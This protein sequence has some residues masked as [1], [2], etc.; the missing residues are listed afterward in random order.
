VITET[1]GVDIF[2]PMTLVGAAVVDTSLANGAV[3]FHE[4]VDG[5]KN[6]TVIAGSGNVFFDQNV[7][8]TTPIGVLTITSA[9]SVTAAGEL[10]ASSIVQTAG[11]G[12]TTFAGAVSTTA[13]AGIALT[14]TQFEFDGLVTTANGGPLLISNSGL[15]S[16]LGGG[17]LSGALSQ[18]G[19]GAVSISGTTSAGGAVSFASAASLTGS[20]S[21]D[22]SANASNIT[23][24]GGITGANNSLLLEAGTTGNIVFGGALSGLGDLTISDAANVTGT[25]ISA[26]TITQSAGT[27]LTSLGNLTTSAVG[28]IALTGKSFSLSGNLIT[29]SLG[30][31]AIVNTGALTLNAG[32]STSI[33]G[34]FSQS[35]GGAI[36]LAGTLLT[37][38]QPISF[39]NDLSLAAAASVSSGT[40]MIAFSGNIDGNKNLTLLGGDLSFGPAI[41]GNTPLST[42]TIQNCANITYPPTF[43]NSIIQNG[44]S[45]LTQIL[46][47]NTLTAT[48]F[49]SLTGTTITQTGTLTTLGSA[50]I[51]ITNSD[52]YTMSGAVNSA[53]L[54]LQAGGGA[55]H[56][57]GVVSSNSSNIT[58]TDALSLTGSSAI[59]TGT[60]IG[61]IRLLST[62]AGAGNDLT[63]TAGAGSIT[64]NSSATGIGTFTIVSGSESTIS[65]ISAAHILQLAGSTT[66]GALTASGALGISLTGSVFALTGNVA[67][68]AGPL[69]IQNT[70][71]LTLSGTTFAIGGALTQAGLGTTTVSSQITASDVISFTG[72]VITSGSPTLDTSAANKAISFQRAVDGSGALGMNSGS[73]DITLV[74]AVG[75]TTRL[76]AL[77]I[78]H[79]G[80]VSA[81]GIRAA[82]MTQAAGE[83]TT[84]ILGNIDTTSG[85]NLTGTHFTINGSLLSS[86]AGSSS[87]AHTG[88]LNLTA[89]ASTLLS[90]SFTESGMGGTVSLSG[91][92]HAS[93][94]NIT[95]ANPITLTAAATFNSDGGGDILISSAIDGPFDLIYTAGTGNI[96]LAAAIGGTTPISSLTIHSAADVTADFGISSGKIIQS[97]GSGLTLFSGP[98]ITTLSDGIVLAGTQFDFE[99]AVTT[100]GGGIVSIAHSGSLNLPATSSFTLDGAFSELGAGA[101]SL[102]TTITTTGD[103]ISFAGAVTLCNDATLDSDTGFGSIVFGNTVSGSHTLNLNTGEGDITFAAAVG[104]VPLTRLNVTS[105]L[106]LTA[107]DIHAGIIDIEGVNRLALFNGTLNTSNPSGVTLSGSAFTL[108][109]NVSTSGGTLAI[110][111]SA[112]LTIAP[113]VTLSIDGGFTQS[114]TGTIYIGGQLTTQNQPILFSGPILLTGNLGLNS[115]NGN[116]TFGSDLN[117]PHSVTITAGTGDVTVPAAFSIEEPL[118]NFTVV[119]SHDINLNGIGSNTAFLSGALSLTAASTISL[120]NTTYSSQSQYYMS[121]ADLDFIHPGLIT[122][123]TS[124]GP[125]IFASASTHLNSSTDLAINTNGGAFSFNAIHGTN[126]ENL[127]I[128]TGSGTATLGALPN[129]GNIN[130]V[131]VNA[132]EIFL[133]AAMNLTNTAF[134]SQGSILNIASPVDIV[135]DNTA[136]FNALGG[137]VGSLVSPILVHTNNLIFAGGIDLAD[138]NGSSIDDTVHP[139]PSNPPCDIIWNSVLIK[140]CTRPIPVPV[141]GG[142]SIPASIRIVFPMPGVESSFFNLAS[143]FYFLPYF[144]N[145]D[146]IRKSVLLYT[147]STSKAPK[148][149]IIKRLKFQVK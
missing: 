46:T 148:L 82:S 43:A 13:A 27:G 87:I 17:S 61:N 1:G 24:S 108:N 51:A 52:I 6:A 48:T 15:L 47:P 78:T 25:S 139:I 138:F 73:A 111:N 50:P 14:G 120:M 129:I 69:F 22:T 31:V 42:L 145:M 103:S 125:I 142:T 39:T 64:L 56:L 57:N 112:L 20:T 41:G 72:P 44:S 137:D 141:P 127:T 134:T 101:V 68:P 124:G 10:F 3:H 135:S 67:T 113:S 76:G 62:I 23:F 110:T 143:D 100:T 95:F 99:N 55:V 90:G 81:Q 83:G 98:L 115:N 65:A 40:G 132:G 130:T 106:N 80:N 77:T 126:F 105:C 5:A 8:H 102:C 97:A 35:G 119:S 136:S 63:L 38:N 149:K 49:I 16:Y 121:G 85:F 53:G 59:L 36:F 89:G 146:Y 74:Q 91:L 79:A 66:F 140:S 123:N 131:T 33:S 133:T 118:V 29:T 2:S 84:T 28:G 18:T 37:I 11:S 92:I 34:A 70:G 109:G 54:F 93:N 128:N 86:A 94:S 30:P 144:L 9:G 4:T 32:A 45:V 75:A 88:L 96:H 71:S 26:A 12:K 7:G 147:R 19:A 114:G 104:A 58:F 60:G 122:L 116:I 107:K 117:G 21:F